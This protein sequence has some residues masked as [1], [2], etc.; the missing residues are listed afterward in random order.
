[1]PGRLHDVPEAPFRVP[2]R[3]PPGGS[4]RRARFRTGGT[5][6]CLALAI[7]AAPP[8]TRPTVRADGPPS[9]ADHRPQLVWAPLFDQTVQRACETG[10]GSTF[11]HPDFRRGQNREERL[12]IIRAGI[13]AAYAKGVRSL[14]IQFFLG[15][16]QLESRYARAYKPGESP[17]EPAPERS[18]P[19][20]PGFADSGEDWVRAVDA[21]NGSHPLDPIRLRLRLAAYASTLYYVYRT[22][23]PYRAFLPKEDPAQGLTRSSQSDLPFDPCFEK[24]DLSDPCFAASPVEPGFYRSF[25]ARGKPLSSVANLANPALRRHIALW[26]G[27]IFDQV[28]AITGRFT[29]I[30]E[31]SLAL[32]AG[33]ESGL[34]GDDAGGV[35]GFSGL[36]YDPKAG[37]EAKAAF[38]AARE[39]LLRETYVGFAAAVHARRNRDDAP[40]RAGI[41]QQAHQLDGRSRGT[42]DLYALLKGAGIDVL[43]HTQPPADYATSMAWTAFSAT[44]AQRLGIAF[45]TEFSWAHFGG[46][47]GADDFLAWRPEKLGIS[48][49]ESFLR[50]A[51]AG[52]AY[53]AGAVVFANWT[54]HEWTRPPARAA[55]RRLVGRPGPHWDDSHLADSGGLFFRP[56]LKAPARV[57]IWISAMGRLACEEAAHAPRGGTGPCEA[58]A[59]LRWFG[60]FGIKA[61]GNGD[62]GGERI[63]IL[64]DGMIRDQPDSLVRYRAIFLPYESS[65]W[66]DPSVLAAFESAPASV[67]DAIRYQ[68][69]AGDAGSGRYAGWKGKVRALDGRPLGAEP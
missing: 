30:E 11:G 49:A 16:N 27:D 18:D 8:P 67:R 58:A 47:G 66:A 41:F 14:D 50:Q 3:A 19:S 34:F 20:L 63:D 31:V 35:V 36:R 42:F 4:A 57:A 69:S 38:F 28:K 65:A 13:R 39:R 48:N 32:D 51:R 12:E 10:Q 7:G 26:A 54:S 2:G 6:G 24:Q 22:R 56:D 45:E 9:R 37:L 5:I 68:R 62:A 46:G 44:V 61:S 59:Y 17:G 33:G 15:R 53:G 29:R 64:T 25:D 43:H 55:W 1:M 21:F 40:A 23:K 52:L 60:D